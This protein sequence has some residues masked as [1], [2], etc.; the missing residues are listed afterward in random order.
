MLNRLQGRAPALPQ[1]S[2]EHLQGSFDTARGGNVSGLAVFLLVSH[3]MYHKDEQVMQLSKSETITWPS[4]RLQKERVTPHVWL[5]IDFAYLAVEVGL[6]VSGQL[7]S[8]QLSCGCSSINLF[9]D[10][11]HMVHVQRSH[12]G[13]TTRESETVFRPSKRLCMWAVSWRASN[14]SAIAHPAVLLLT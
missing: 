2:S 7:S 14:L 4:E 1:I 11:V 3:F 6:H 5:A 8:I 10:S 12:L 9:A 13:V